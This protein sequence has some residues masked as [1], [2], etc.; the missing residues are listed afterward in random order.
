MN[1]IFGKFFQQPLGEAFVFQKSVI[2]LTQAIFQT[3][4]TTKDSSYHLVREPLCGCVKEFRNKLINL[5]S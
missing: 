3:H 1:E 5:I 4:K 2:G